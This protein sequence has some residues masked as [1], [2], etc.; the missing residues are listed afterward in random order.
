MSTSVK[1]HRAPGDCFHVLLTYGPVEKRVCCHWP[2]RIPDSSHTHSKS[3]YWMLPTQPPVVSAEAIVGADRHKPLRLR[4]YTMEFPNKVSDVFVPFQIFSRRWRDV[5]MVMSIGCSSRGPELD[6]R[7]WHGG[8]TMIVNPVARNPSTFFWSPWAPG[9]HMVQRHKCRQNTHVQ[10]MKWNNNKT[11][12]KQ[13][14]CPLQFVHSIFAGN[15]I[16]RDEI[17]L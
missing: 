13:N 10:K 6:S 14:P 2:S 1:P 15:F 7:H 9:A 8:S 11:N 12:K 5:S 17:E 16:H 3:M 4:V